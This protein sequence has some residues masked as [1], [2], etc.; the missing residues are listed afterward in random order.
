MLLVLA[1]RAEGTLVDK[2][3]RPVPNVRVE[4]TWEWAWTGRKGSDSFITDA[5]GHFEFPRVKGFSVT[6]LVLPHEPQINLRFIAHG[7]NGPVS[8]YEVIR[9]D[10][11]ERAGDDKPLN[12]VSRID[13][14]PGITLG[15]YW[16]TVVEMK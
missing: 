13:L 4:R 3:L 6:A 14:E 7:T 15:M 12:F 5:Q 11:F 8:L 16:G 10:Y 1:T 2:D 9:S